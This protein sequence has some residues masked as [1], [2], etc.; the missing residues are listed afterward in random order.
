MRP[1][2]LNLQR[3]PCALGRSARLHLVP[4]TPSLPVCVGLHAASTRTPS[5][6]HAAAVPGGGVCWRRDAV[7][8][9]KREVRRLCI[10]RAANPNEHTLGTA[11]HGITR[12]GAQTPRSG[13][14]AAGPI[15]VLL[16]STSLQ[17][18][19]TTHGPRLAH[20]GTG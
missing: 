20:G 7:C 2:V 10:A 9:W 4:T 19:V 15:Y 18:P 1:S 3:R 12:G 16:T 5:K 8:A 14:H 17:L 13:V 11:P 6:G